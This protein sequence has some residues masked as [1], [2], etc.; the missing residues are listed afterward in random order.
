MN[1]AGIIIVIASTYPFGESC[2]SIAGS[3]CSLKLM[4]LCP[5]SVSVLFKPFLGLGGD[6]VMTLNVFGYSISFHKQQYAQE[7]YVG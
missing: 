3:G 5:A 1:P 2:G 6:G 4:Q 7:T